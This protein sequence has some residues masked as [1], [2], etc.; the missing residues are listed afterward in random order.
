MSTPPLSPKAYPPAM[1]EGIVDA[2]RTAD[3]VRKAHRI[4]R[5]TYEGEEA[6]EILELII[7]TL[8]GVARVSAPDTYSA[9]EWL[10]YIRRAPDRFFSGDLSTTAPYDRTLAETLMTQSRTEVPPAASLDD[11]GF[12]PTTK[13]HLAKAEQGIGFAK[14]VSQFH[15]TFRMTNKGAALH[16][17]AW[18]ED[19]GAPFPYFFTEESAEL[20]QAVDAFDRRVEEQRG[21]SLFGTRPIGADADIESLGEDAI[22]LVQRQPEVTVMPAAALDIPADLFP[23][24]PGIPGIAVRHVMFPFDLS[25][26]AEFLGH[27]LLGDV[28][29]WHEDV[30]TLMG[31]LLFSIWMMG[32]SPTSR[33]NILQSGYG[34]IR[35]E[36]VCEVWPALRE[37]FGDVLNERFV[38]LVERTPADGEDFLDALIGMRGSGWPL[39]PGPV[40]CRVTEAGVVMDF[41]SAS[42]RLIKTLRYPQVT[43]AESNVRADLFEVQTQDAINSTAWEPP[44]QFAKLRGRDLK[45]DGDVIGEVDAVGYRGGQL[46]LVSCK[47]ILFTPE[48]DVGRY[49]LVRNRATR[50][51]N[52]VERWEELIE[53]LRK[54]PVGDN[55]DLSGVDEIHGVVITP[56]VMFVELSTLTRESL[57]D[58]RYYSSYQELM[59]WLRDGGAERGQS[60]AAR[61]G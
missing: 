28:R 29:L 48:Y 52:A 41:E 10:F 3:I 36:L 1:A 46:L 25:D 43:G 22:P 26:F 5:G 15:R 16:I 13:A 21:G 4:Q 39:T 32:S 20:R 6:S 54:N 60:P 12:F 49:N 47:S 59:E 35:D 57:P 17:E 14:A 44:R 40:A 19:W 34:L 53:R 37:S 23:S 51:A 55:F 11:R 61:R 7:R 45:V 38:P 8:Q 42:T 30:P 18:G 31:M 50:I 56:S 33:K 9:Y 27:P 2:Y 58:L 24:A